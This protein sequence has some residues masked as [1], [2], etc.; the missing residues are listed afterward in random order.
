MHNPI[1][2]YHSLVLYH[3]KMEE[4][5]KAIECFK[6]VLTTDPR[7]LDSKN[8]IELLIKKLKGK[9]NH[10]NGENSLETDNKKKQGETIFV[11]I[12]KNEKIVKKHK[13][14]SDSEIKHYQNILQ[15]YGKY[16][17][18]GFPKKDNHLPKSRLED[19]FILRE[20]ITRDSSNKEEQ[21]TIAYG[22]IHKDNKEIPSKKLRILSSN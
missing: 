19:K 9:E 21:G 18:I 3:S 2:K 7:H 13:R 1:D 15:L 5:N 16:G 17:T 6:K 14:L 22:G 11:N 20:S 4:Y 12:P 10:V 8:K